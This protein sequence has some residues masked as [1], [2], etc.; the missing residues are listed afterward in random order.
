[1]RQT[2]ALFVT[3]LSMTAAFA[4]AQGCGKKDT[5]PAAEGSEE[6]PPASEGDETPP[7]KKAK[8]DAGETPDA[9][10][11][12]APKGRHGLRDRNGKRPGPVRPKGP[13][14]EPADGPTKEPAT[15]GDPVTPKDE[16][17]TNVDA[18][19]PPVVADAPKTDPG[20]PPVAADAPKPDAPAPPT[21]APVGDAPK[22][23]GVGGV[24]HRTDLHH[25]AGGVDAAL[26]LPLAT[27]LEITSAKG[28]EAQGFLPGIAPAMGYGSTFYA[29]PGAAHFGVALQVWQD[30]SRRES[31][32]R[33][34]RMRLQ[35]PNA[36]DITV[37]QP[38]RAYYSY[39]QGI[40]S[41]IFAD[42]SR[43]MIVAIGCGE[44]VCNQEQLVKL[45]KAARDRL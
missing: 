36:E 42:P 5:P 34:R 20:T 16:P 26:I 11:G 2:P 15:A 19:T 22:G 32:D 30:V 1:M 39:F 45:A 8:K 14:D 24:A 29:A 35:Y 28:L 7:S 4:V 25:A 13:S 17:P 37:L 31:D 18:A 38:L 9:P 10:D 21:P 23:E 40:Q 41:L 43:R 6:T 44:G 27:V 12:D 3:L 33:Y